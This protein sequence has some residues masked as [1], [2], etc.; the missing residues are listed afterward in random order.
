MVPGGEEKDSQ[1]KKD[2]LTLSRSTLL[3]SLQEGFGPIIMTNV[4][5]AQVIWKFSL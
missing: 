5:N 2:E 4:N 3:F 1:K